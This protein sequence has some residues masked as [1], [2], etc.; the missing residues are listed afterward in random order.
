M[1]TR[2]TR[3]ARPKKKKAAT[4]SGRPQP[5]T[6]RGQR[7]RENLLKAAEKIFGEKGYHSASIVD[8]VREADVAQ[9]TFYVHFESKHAIFAELLRSLNHLIR[10]RSQSASAKARDFIEAE[11]L[12]FQAFFDFVRERPHIY[13]LIWEAEFVDPQLRREHYT[14]ITG[15]WGRRISAALN[16]KGSRELDVEAISYC[17]FGIAAFVAIRWPYWSGGPIPP[18]VFQSVLRFIRNGIGP[19]LK[20]DGATKN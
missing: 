19:Y 12:G 9:G 8:I 10:A 1:T 15:N 3:T 16:E 11:E 13:R 6:E 14:K 4:K 5:V 18:R 2:S 20:D 17:L 7:S